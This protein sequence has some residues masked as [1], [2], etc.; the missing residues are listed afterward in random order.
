MGKEE[1][2][3]STGRVY[4]YSFKGEVNTDHV[5]DVAT[6]RAIEMGVSALIVASETGRSALKVAKLLKDLNAGLKLVVVTHPPDET[7]GS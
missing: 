4:Y 1:N 6:R 7:W 3:I 5:I 2:Y